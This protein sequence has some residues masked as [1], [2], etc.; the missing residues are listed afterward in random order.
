MR[1]PRPRTSLETLWREIPEFPGYSVSDTG[2]V[3]ND[4]T[5]RTLTQFVNAAGVSYVGLTSE[6]RQRSRSV[7]LL[8]AESYLPEPSKWFDTPIHLNGDRTNNAAWNLMWRP[9][10]FA[11]KYVQQF[12]GPNV[13]YDPRLI[14]L[15]T[16]EEV[17]CWE[18]CTRLGLLFMHVLVS[19]STDDMNKKSPFGTD[20]HFTLLA[21][22][23]NA[24]RNRRL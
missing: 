1:I 6:R 8:V 24:R 22:H 12:E 15:E 11:I 16:G 9:R 5:G 4:E 2:L 10:W 17:R 3:R 19:A 21:T 14:I 18:V 23:T 7:A 20:L 13:D